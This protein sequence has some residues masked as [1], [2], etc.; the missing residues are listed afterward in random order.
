MYFHVAGKSNMW[1]LINIEQQC[2]A[3]TADLCNP[4]TIYQ[5]SLLSHIQETLKRGSKA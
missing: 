4:S 3:D 2:S 5:A 1:I